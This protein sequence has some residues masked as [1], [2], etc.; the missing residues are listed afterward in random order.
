MFLNMNKSFKQKNVNC[1]KWE[2]SN[3]Q[4]LKIEIINLQRHDEPQRF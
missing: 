4:V 3:K 1:I 2:K